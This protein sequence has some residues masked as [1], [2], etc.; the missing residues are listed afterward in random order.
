MLQAEVASVIGFNNLLEGFYTAAGMPV[1]DVES[2]FA[3]TNVA[4]VGG[5]P[6]NVVRV[7]QWT[8]MCAPAPLGP[9]IHLNPA[10]YG[11]VAQAFLAA[12]PA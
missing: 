9:D 5:V 2:A 6:F 7:C 10:G 8:W 3:S 1:A 11:V 4:L 12:I